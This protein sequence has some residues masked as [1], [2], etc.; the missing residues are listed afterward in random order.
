[1]YRIATKSWKFKSGKV[2]YDAARERRRNIWWPPWPETRQRKVTSA[3]QAT[4]KRG[5][6][7]ETGDR[8]L[9]GQWHA[10]TLIKGV[11]CRKGVSTGEDRVV[12]WGRR[13]NLRVIIIRL[14]KA[15]VRLLP[16][17]WRHKQS[18]GTSTMTN[19]IV[20]CTASFHFRH[21]KAMTRNRQSKHWK[22]YTSVHG[23][24]GNTVQSDGKRKSR[25]KTKFW[26]KAQGFRLPHPHPTQKHT[27][28]LL[29]GVM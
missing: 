24:F 18:W 17:M 3:D 16:S 10:L 6:S 11:R 20:H 26:E 1:M 7:P 23:G 29:S 13:C 5:W 15:H 28:K 2:R 8:S 9:N 22:M 19:S 27:R 12:M 25:Q 21:D 4:L 14:L